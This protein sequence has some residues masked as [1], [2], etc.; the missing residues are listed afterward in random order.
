ME[1]RER[2]LA[3]IDAAIER[4]IADVEAGRVHDADAVFDEL[5][6]RY[7]RMA[8]ERGEVKGE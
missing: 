8:R 5:E 3:V 2:H 4:G 7:A 6:A 1:E